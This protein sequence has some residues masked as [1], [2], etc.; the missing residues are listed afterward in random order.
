MYIRYEI[1]QI[2]NKFVCNDFK[3]EKFPDNES[4][5]IYIYIHFE[6]YIISILYINVRARGKT[7]Y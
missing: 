4:A 5:E 3:L 1:R 6:Y 2:M 7:H